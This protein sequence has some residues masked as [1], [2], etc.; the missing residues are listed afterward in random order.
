MP[1][2]TLNHAASRNQTY[3][4]PLA[5][6]SSRQTIELVQQYNQNLRNGVSNTTHS[7]QT[8]MISA[9][10]EDD[11]AMDLTEF[12][13]ASQG[14]TPTNPSAPSGQAG[15]QPNIEQTLLLSGRP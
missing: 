15:Q 3:Q 11:L 10:L 1:S 12:T 13:R 6:E 8:I 5:D 4:D 7:L 14:N 2:V 9:A